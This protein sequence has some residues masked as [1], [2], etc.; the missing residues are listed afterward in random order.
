MKKCRYYHECKKLVTIMGPIY[1][2]YNECKKQH[3][4]WDLHVGI[5]YLKMALWNL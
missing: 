2:Y 1:E 5:A 4:L 3:L